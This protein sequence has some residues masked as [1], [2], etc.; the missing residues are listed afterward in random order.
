MFDRIAYEE[1]SKSMALK[2]YL[3]FKLGAGKNKQTILSSVINR[4]KCFSTKEILRLT[5]SDTIHLNKMNNFKSAL[6]IV[7]PET[8]ENCHP[9]VSI[10]FSQ[11]SSILSLWKEPYNKDEKIRQTRIFYDNFASIGIIPE[12]SKTIACS[13]KTNTSHTIIAK[14]IAQIKSLYRDDWE[15][16]I[17]CS[18]ALL[19]FGCKEY[20]TVEYVSKELGKKIVHT[21]TL[22]TR[23]YFHEINKEYK[24]VER[25]YIPD[26]MSPDEIVNMKEDECVLIIKGLR[27]FKCKKY[28][29]KNHP[30]YKHTGDYKEKNIYTHKRL[31]IPYY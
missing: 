6:F 19:C 18:S 24:K 2:Q 8:A 28:N 30:Y 31:E 26:L 17:G 1:M 7:V 22:H 13:Y 4:M 25:H 12:F 14:N 5:N 21:T 20:S 9:I 10:I 23:D 11:L 3:A 16:I 27:P 15:S 29:Y